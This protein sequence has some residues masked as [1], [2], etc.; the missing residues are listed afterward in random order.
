[1][2]FPKTGKQMKVSIFIGPTY[3]QRLK[4]MVDDKIHSRSSGPKVVITRQPTEG[5]ARNGGLRFGEMERD[6]MI[7]HGA[8]MFVK[9]TFME[10]SDNYK[11]HVCNSCGCVAS[12]NKRR[13]IYHCKQCD[14]HSNF[15][16]IR[17]PYA[18]KLFYQEMESMSIN[19]KFRM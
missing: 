16:E 17:V 10:R 18:Y 4:H 6:C 9:E 7:A 2:S 3:Y 11:I 12:V 5:R 1:M 19:A 13:Q 8:S 15:S 14:N